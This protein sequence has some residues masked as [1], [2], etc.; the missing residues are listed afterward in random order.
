MHP[1]NTVFF[2]IGNVLVK[3]VDEEI[4]KRLVSKC[5]KSLC[6]GLVL[7][8]VPQLSALIY[9]YRIGEITTPQFAKSSVEILASNF[10][11]TGDASYFRESFDV[12][13]DNLIEDNFRIYEA[14]ARTKDIKV[15]IISDNNEA[16]TAK[17]YSKHPRIFSVIPENRIILSQEV[18]CQKGESPLI[19]KKAATMLGSDPQECIMIDDHEDK[20]IGA[21]SIGMQAI[22]LTE[23]VSLKDELC[24]HGISFSL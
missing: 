22:V 3:I 7:P 6:K 5:N 15:G 24:S 11:Y 19:F 8:R 9:T 23:G 14:L 2:D 18:H 16:H 20:V 1:I 13:I 10:G 17:L 12:S 21:K 4:S